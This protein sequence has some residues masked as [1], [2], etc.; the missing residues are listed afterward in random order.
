MDR[1]AGGLQSLGSQSQTRLKQVSTHSGFSSV[2]QLCPTLCHSVDCSNHH[3]IEPSHSCCIH[4][5]W[6]GLSKVPGPTGWM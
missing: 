3:A 2:A 6:L 4:E 1:G 5:R